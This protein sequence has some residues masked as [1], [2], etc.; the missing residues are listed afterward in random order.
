MNDHDKHN[1]MGSRGV[2]R[3]M[4]E[5]KLQNGQQDHG[6]HGDHEHHEHHEHHDQSGHSQGDHSS[7]H[8]GSNHGTGHSSGHAMSHDDRLQMLS[9]HHKQT[10]WIYWTLPLLGIWLLTAPF[11]F[12]YLNEALWVDPSGGRGPWF[13]EQ[14]TPELQHQRALLMT[15]SD[16][17][18]GLLLL[19]FGWRSLKPNRPYSLWTCCFVGVW[20]TFAPILFWA[21]TASSY[22]NDSLIGI[23]VM[24]L[25]ILIPGMPNM[26]MYMQHGAATPPGWSYNPSSW[27]Q[28]WIMIAT[29]FLGFL[30]SRYLAMFQLGYIDYVWDP[31]FGFTQGTEKVLNSDMSHLW[32]ISDGG[33]GVISYTFEF[34]MGYMGSPSRWRTMPWMVCFFGI[35]VIPLGLT[36]IVL[37]I[38]QPVIVHRWCAFC[39][40][41]A[42]VM[43]PMIPL[44]VD[45]VVA[46]IQHVR[47]AKARGDRGGSLWKIFW[48]GGR[49]DGCT[50]DERSPEMISL[51]DQPGAVLKASIWGMSFPWTLITTSA[52]GLLLMCLPT[53]FS[54]DIKTHA[55]DIGHLGGAL[56][57]TVS[58]ICMGEVIRTGRFLNLLLAA[59]VAVGP[60]MVAEATTGYAALCSVIAVAVAALSLPRG[61]ITESYGSWDRFIR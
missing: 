47:Q 54:I 14:S 61:Q 9:M 33:L 32:P 40:L 2:T 10:L 20:L 39:L 49:A 15:G 41:A 35:L 60:W 38:S 13:A 43:L 34:L 19:I 6:D 29:G 17:L 31:L 57:V 18:C 27:P 56:I 7:N 30:V 5:M 26:I 53:W 36:H 50:M 45:E 51:P 59:A 25:T 22:A 52:L 11:N 1:M 58:V 48:K 21:P 16:V 8:E 4:A 28:R 42:L 23:L 44:E 12:G 37:V 55:A 24:A 46:M 3:P